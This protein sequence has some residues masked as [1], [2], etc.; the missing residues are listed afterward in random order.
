MKVDTNIEANQ[1]ED[2]IAKAYE[3]GNVYIKH[4]FSIDGRPCIGGEVSKPVTSFDHINLD[5]EH[6]S[7]AS[8]TSNGE[9]IIIARP[10]F[11]REGKCVNIL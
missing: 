7:D 4:E 2:R 5:N 9:K 11:R 10:V 1:S 6:E 3:T 8:L